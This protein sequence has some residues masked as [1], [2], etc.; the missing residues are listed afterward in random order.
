[1][2]PRYDFEATGVT[3][4]ICGSSLWSVLSGLLTPLLAV[5]AGYIAYRQW[6][7]AHH[8]LRFDLFD[9]RLAIH[10]VA[11]ELIA[12]IT[13]SGGVKMQDYV[14]LNAGTRQARWLLDKGMQDYFDNEMLPKVARLKSLV[15][16][17]EGLSDAESRGRNLKMQRK[18]RDWIEQQRTV[19][20]S[21]FDRFLQ[22][23]SS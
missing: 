4:V 9:R 23:P 11:R 21:K 13:I 1:L 19:I 12:I 10:S 14:R 16:E 7:T 17:L 20:D 3:A 22:M 8:R 18:L 2:F 6:R 15:A 5:I